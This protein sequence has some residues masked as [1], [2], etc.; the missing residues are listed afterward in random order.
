MKSTMDATDGTNG[1]IEANRLHDTPKYALE[2]LPCS[3]PGVHLSRDC[4]PYA[5]AEEFA[6]H[7][8]CLGQDHFTNDAI[9]R[10]SFALTGT[11]RTLYSAVTLMQAWHETSVARKVHSIAAKP[12]FARVVRVRDM[13]SW[14]EAMFDFETA[15]EPPASCTMM[16]SLVPGSDGQ[17]KIWLLGTILEQFEGTGNVDMLEPSKHNFGDSASNG[18]EECGPGHFDC[19]VVGAGQAGLS[20][21]GRLAA[22]GLEYVI[23]DKNQQVG[24]NWKNRYGSARLHTSRESSH[25]PFDRTFPTDMYPKFL[26]KDDLAKGYRDWAS[27]FDINVW[28]STSLESGS[29]DSSSRKWS[30]KIKKDGQERS[31]T[32]KAVVLALGAGCQ[33]PAM[34]RWPGQETFRGIIKHSVEY[35]TAEEWRGK[36]GVVVGTA[37][38]AHDVAEDFVQAGLSSTTMI[39]RSRTYVMPVEYYTPIS[40]LGYNDIIPTTVADRTSNWGPLAVAR[41]LVNANL[42]AAARNQPERFDALERAGFCTERYGDL[43]YQ[44]YVRLGGHYIDVGASA[45]IAKGLIKVKSDAVPVRYVEQGIEFS[46]GT[47]LEADVIIHATGFVGNMRGEVYRIFGADVGDQ[48]DDFWGIDKEGEISG[49]F[50]PSGRK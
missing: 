11:L 15:A 36:R 44:L 38:T 50:R 4:D 20:T 21:G 17:W 14:V 26:G 7:L 48:V 23:L 10:D 30:L 8:Q 22:L 12:A 41:L 9:W 45:K 29:W 40:D 37:N 24:D 16:V 28:L 39:Q 34:P 32:T 42:H 27:K 35:T 13:S 19:V 25:L 3:L 5:I 6:P 18:N 2:T 47:L 49:A 46:D 33:I 1:T 31:I 43:L